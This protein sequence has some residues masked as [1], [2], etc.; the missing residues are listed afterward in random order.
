MDQ[1]PAIPDDEVAITVEDL[2][3]PE[4]FARTVDDQNTL[5]SVTDALGEVVQRFQYGDYGAPRVLD[6][7][8]GSV[9]DDP[10]SPHLYTGRPMIAG[11]GIVLL[12]YRYRV[13]NPMLGRFAQVDPEW[14]T[15]YNE[16]MTG[17]VITIISDYRD[18]SNH[19]IIRE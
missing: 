10:L 5:L 17:R 14:T 13:I 12:D 18:C 15:Y 4:D 19:E 11:A 16:R 6:E 1:N 8:G 7:S 2:A 3:S 9:P